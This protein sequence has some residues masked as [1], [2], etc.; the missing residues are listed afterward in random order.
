[1]QQYP[2]RQLT[3]GICSLTRA[4]GAAARSTVEEEEEEE[5]EGSSLALREHGHP[6][7]SSICSFYWPLAER[8]A[9]LYLSDA[10]AEWP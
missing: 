6:R 3:K 8:G 10:A 7:W 9:A 5:E 4:G 1:M 2:T